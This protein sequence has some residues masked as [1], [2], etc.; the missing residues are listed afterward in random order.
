[1]AA[2]SL[3]DNNRSRFLKLNLVSGFTSNAIG[4]WAKAS[5]AP[6]CAVISDGLGCFARVTTAGCT[7]QAVVV[8]DRKPRD[9]SQFLWVNIV[10]GN[11]KTALAGA[12]HSLKYRKYADHYLA[13]FAYR[14]NRRFDLRGLVS[15]PIVGVARCAPIREQVVR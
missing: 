8:G 3:D 1:M 9:P 10:L 15:R 11:L 13:A 12:Y 4:K 2:V 14:F 5:L 6:G 7:H